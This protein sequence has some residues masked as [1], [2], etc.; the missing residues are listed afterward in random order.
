MYVVDSNHNHE[1][2]PIVFVDTVELVSTKIVPGHSSNSEPLLNEIIAA[3]IKQPTTTVNRNASL[4]DQM[5][6]RFAIL[7]QKLQKK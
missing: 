4:R 6:Q 3:T 1:T 2:D 7:N 5:K